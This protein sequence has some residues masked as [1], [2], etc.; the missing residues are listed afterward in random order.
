MAEPS[1]GRIVQHVNRDGRMRPAIIVE[2]ISSDVVHLQVFRTSIDGPSSDGSV[3]ER[4]VARVDVAPEG[5]SYWQWPVRTPVPTVDIGEFSEQRAAEKA[6]A[7]KRPARVK[8]TSRRK[9]PA[10]P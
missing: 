7:P 2:V 10:T 3:F 1:I 5:E 6:A 9:P 4:D 8:K